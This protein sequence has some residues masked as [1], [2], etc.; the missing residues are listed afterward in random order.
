MTRWN[1]IG[2]A[3]DAGV[4]PAP[5]TAAL[6]CVLAILSARQSALGQTGLKVLISV[7]MEG[8]TGVVSPGQFS[9]TT[10]FEYERFRKFMTDETLAA[11][12]GAREAGATEFVVVDAHGNGENL[13]IERFASDTR[14]VRS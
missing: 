1:M 13:L 5:P 9:Q 7:D 2:R 12:Q 14:I 3:F 11:V 6:L 8:I 4:I 10:G